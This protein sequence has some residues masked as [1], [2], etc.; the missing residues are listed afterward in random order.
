MIG[1]KDQA[2][3]P[4]GARRSLGL[5]G[6]EHSFPRLRKSPDGGGGPSGEGTG[7]WQEPHA[8]HGSEARGKG[9]CVCVCE[10][11]QSVGEEKVSRGQPDTTQVAA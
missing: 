5:W 4:A 7:S 10:H 2:R 9:M 8:F 6:H 1:F 11:C 3:A